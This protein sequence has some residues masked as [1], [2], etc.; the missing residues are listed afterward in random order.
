MYRLVADRARHCT[1]CES[2]SARRIHNGGQA[3]FAKGIIFQAERA[4]N[5]RAEILS[6]RLDVKVKL[7]LCLTKHHAMKTYWGVEVYLHTFLTS[8]LDGGEWSAS[9]PVHFTPSYSLIMGLGLE[10]VAK[11]K[12]SRHCPFQELNPVRP[13]RSLVSTE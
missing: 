11:R 8:A 5:G 7:S 10:A 6:V 9:P 12:I 13:A 4:S 2:L 3:V 1:L